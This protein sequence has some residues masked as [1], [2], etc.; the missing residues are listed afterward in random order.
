MT[1]QNFEAIF[2]AAIA[3]D[4]EKFKYFDKW[5]N[6]ELPV[7]NITSFQYLCEER[8]FG[9]NQHLFHEGSHITHL[10]FIKEG[11]VEISRRIKI[12][13]R[14]ED[15]A[16]FKSFTND[17]ELGKNGRY[18]IPGVRPES[19]GIVSEGQLIGEDDFLQGNAYWTYSAKVIHHP[20]K[21]YMIDKIKFQSSYIYIGP[22]IEQLK[23]FSVAKKQWRQKQTINAFEMN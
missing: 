20:T 13:G 16:L 15:R 22:I 8:S 23:K 1:K 3:A 21:V 10:F 2:A 4:E 19:I 7:S 17:R 14:Y 11:D 5:F 6:N 9:R 12:N 18:I